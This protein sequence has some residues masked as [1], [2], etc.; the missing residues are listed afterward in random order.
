[1]C[2]VWG[3]AAQGV[4]GSVFL[5]F[6]SLHG[7][8]KMSNHFSSAV[9]VTVNNN[10]F[11]WN[12]F[13]SF[14]LRFGYPV[15]PIP[16]QLVAVPYPLHRDGHLGDREKGRK[17]SPKGI[18]SAE[19]VPTLG[20]CLMLQKSIVTYPFHC[21]CTCAGVSVCTHTHTHMLMCMV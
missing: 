16:R 4:D 7:K 14:P 11:S 10:L 6:P 1:M 5:R 20:I 17:K 18:H 13:Q 3:C 12:F 19:C 15:R 21:W 2:A 9:S 8:K